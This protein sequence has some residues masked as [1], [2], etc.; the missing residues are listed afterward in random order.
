VR[1]DEQAVPVS[2]YLTDATTRA[3]VALAEYVTL[4][5]QWQLVEIPL[6]AFTA[7]GVDQTK[8]TGFEVA[9]EY[10]TGSGILWIDNIRLGTTSAPQAD[11]RSLHFQ[12]VDNHPLALHLPNGKRWQVSSDAPW[13]TTSIVTGAGPDTLSVQTFPWNM[14]K[15]TYTGKL[16]IQTE[17]DQQESITVT[18]T[19]VN[20][21]NAASQIFLPFVRR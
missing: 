9:F 2:I 11:R 10:A 4:N 8:L 18:L 13:L 5:G 17:D 6:T 12:D 21:S 15:G 19:V 14:E 3:Q 1:G 7:K 16:M 20:P